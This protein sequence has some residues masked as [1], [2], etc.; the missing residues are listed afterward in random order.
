MVPEHNDRRDRRPLYG[1]FPG[2]ALA[3]AGPSVSICRLRRVA[4]RMASR[5]GAGV[6][7]QLLEGAFE[8][9]AGCLGA[10]DRSATPANSELPRSGAGLC[11]FSGAVVW[12]CRAEP[13]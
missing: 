13:S 7:G 1:V 8:G 3:V 6:A 4:A 10:A 9:S 11:R 12:A 2:K 5:R